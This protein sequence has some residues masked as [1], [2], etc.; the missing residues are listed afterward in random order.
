MEFLLLMLRNSIFKLLSKI[1]IDLSIS[2]CRL[3]GAGGL[4]EDGTGVPLAGVGVVAVKDGGL[5][6]MVGGENAR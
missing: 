4:L 2:C 3:E 5:N 6:D 1:L